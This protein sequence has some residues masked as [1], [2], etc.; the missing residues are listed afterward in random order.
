VGEMGLILTFP[1]EAT[2]ALGGPGGSA[3]R[4]PHRRAPGSALA[5]PL[6]NSVAPLWYTLQGKRIYKPYGKNARTDLGI[7]MRPT[8]GR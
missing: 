6:G 2:V 3:D 8:V 1:D 5:V 7:W 4:S